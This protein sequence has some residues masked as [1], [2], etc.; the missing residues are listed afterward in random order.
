MDVTHS[1]DTQVRPYSRWQNSRAY[2]LAVCA[3]MGWVISNK[4][5][6]VRNGLTN[7]IFI[8][9][10]DTGVGGGVIALP[11]FSRDFG[12]LSDDK[13]YV[14]NTQGNVVS[15]LQG[16]WYVSFLLASHN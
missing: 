12:L 2:Y 7:S 5:E 10:Y 4:I 9:G 8:F 11:S 14:A 1:L 3:Y 16:G 6:R 15:I 13:T